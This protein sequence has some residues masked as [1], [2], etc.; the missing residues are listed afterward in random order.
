[1]ASLG[2]QNKAT[3]SAAWGSAL[4]FTRNLRKGPNTNPEGTEFLGK[5]PLCHLGLVLAGSARCS[6]CT[7]G[8]GKGSL[9]CAF[10]GMKKNICFAPPTLPLLLPECKATPR[11]PHWQP[12]WECVF[13]VIVSTKIAAEPEDSPSPSPS[14]QRSS[15]RTGAKLP[16]G[17]WPGMERLRRHFLSAQKSP[18]RIPDSQLLIPFRSLF[19]SCS[20]SLFKRWEN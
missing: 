14:L 12:L 18:L 9:A 4:R 15:S 7:A 11:S 6:S 1:M 10:L 20:A 5:S 8:A 2:S 17:I 13:C 3:G 16:I 19:V